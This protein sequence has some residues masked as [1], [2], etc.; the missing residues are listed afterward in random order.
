MS[1]ARRI[2]L[3]ATRLCAVAILVGCVCLSILPRFTIA[4]A[5]GVNSCCAGESAR[6][7]S[8]SI[9]RVR[10]APKPEPMC[11]LKQ[12][13]SN[14]D[15]VTVI[16]DD[17]EAPSNG[18]NAFAN[19]DRCRDCPTCGL[20]SKQRT[21]DKSFTPTQQPI[22]QDSNVALILDAYPNSLRPQPQFKLISP[23]GPPL[24]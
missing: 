8:V 1:R 9:R 23:R 5:A 16:A 22:R 15:S 10:K 13:Q 6:H 11:G 14:E 24:S 19:P 3:L 4:S 20:G 7:C 2:L 12:A 21:R 17:N 18:Q